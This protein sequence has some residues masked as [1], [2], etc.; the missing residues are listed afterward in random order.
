MAN[1]NV[2]NVAN[3]STADLVNWRNLYSPPAMGANTR[4]NLVNSQNASLGVLEAINNMPYVFD[5]RKYIG[6]TP[7][8]ISA[9][10]NPH[11]A[12]P[13]GVPSQYQGLL[14]MLQ[15][16]PVTQQGPG[17]LPLISLLR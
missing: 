4:M 5:P 9:Q 17:A 13:P 12:I 8:D 7:Q 10:V 6:Q 3:R 2:P 16:E 14:Q 15:G 11:A 1:P